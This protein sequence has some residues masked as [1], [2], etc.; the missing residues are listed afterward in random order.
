MRKNLIILVIIAAS[1]SFMAC[2]DSTAS[3]AS[4]ATKWCNLNAKVHGATSDPEK[5]QAK[6]TLEDFEKEMEKKHDKA[7]MKKVEDE[8]EKCENASEGR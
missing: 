4:I 7:F 1:Y 5:D 2:N 6:K 3:P 8:I